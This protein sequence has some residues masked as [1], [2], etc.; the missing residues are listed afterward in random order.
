MHGIDAL[1]VRS[2]N[3]TKKIR[4]QDKWDTK[5]DKIKLSIMHVSFLSCIARAHNYS[6]CA[7]CTIFPLLVT[8]LRPILSVNL[9]AH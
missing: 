4:V 7:A 8:D 3:E 6:V 9:I 5:P 1:A 2:E